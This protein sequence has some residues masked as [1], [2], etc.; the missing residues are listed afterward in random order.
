[1]SAGFSTSSISKPDWYDAGARPRPTGIFRF[2]RN[3]DAERRDGS[4]ESVSDKRLERFSDCSRL[5]AACHIRSELTSQ[6]C[7]CGGGACRGTDAGSGGSLDAPETNLD[8][9]L[10]V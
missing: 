7:T 5:R 1:H 4:V 8:S 9:L 10:R 3:R 2:A 6:V